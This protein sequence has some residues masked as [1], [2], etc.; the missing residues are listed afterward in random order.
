MVVLLPALRSVTMV[1]MERGHKLSPALREPTPMP[2][3]LVAH[4]MEMQWE[5]VEV[6]VEQMPLYI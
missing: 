2:G 3:S 4:R 1:V 6:V 5:P